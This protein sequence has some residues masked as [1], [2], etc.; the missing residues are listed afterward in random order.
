MDTKKKYSVAILGDGGWG[1][2]LAM[3]NVR[4]GNDVILWSGFPDYAEVLRE[5]RENIKFLPGVKIDKRIR[6]TSDIREAFES[7]EILV[8]AIPTQ[9]LR[10][11]L[12]KVRDF[13]SQDKD[14]LY[15]SVAKGI[16]KKTGLRPS[17]IIQ[18]I[19]GR[20][21]PLAVLSGPSHAEEVSRKLPT[22]LVAASAREKNAQTV[23]DA[24][25]DSYF[26]IYAQTDVVGTELGGALKNII[27]IAVGICDGLKLGDNTK[28]GL[29]TRGLFEMMR[30]GVRFG[31]NPN[32]FFGLSGLGDMVT[33]CYSK[34]G[35]NL[36]VGR[37]IGGGKRLKEIL[38]SMEMVAEGVPTAESVHQLAEKMRVDLPIMREVYQILFKEKD[39]RQAVMDLMQRDARAEWRQY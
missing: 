15:V 39:P 2:A 31:A 26:R 34:H 13:K 1:T 27:A 7:G 8:L 19:L 17:E 24:F 25:M 10:N 30:L 28:A 4:R 38:E 5:R 18:S 22:L 36:R 37:L 32:T 21:V 33:T 35:R 29:I 9:Y 23:Q 20:E 6:I 11:V 16:E 14:K 12:F 3:V